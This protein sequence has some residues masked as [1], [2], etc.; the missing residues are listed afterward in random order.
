MDYLPPNQFNVDLCM[1]SISVLNRIPKHNQT[2]APYE[3]MMGKRMDQ[4]RYL[5]VEWGEPVVVKRPKGTSSD[6]GTTGQWAVVVRRVMNGT[7]VVKV[8]LIQTKKY[9][10][11][12][13]LVH[14]IAPD[15][16]LEALKSISVDQN[17]GLEEEG[18]MEEKQV[19]E[20]IEEVESHDN[21]DADADIDA[22]ENEEDVALIGGHDKEAVV[23]QSIKSIEGTWNDSNVKVEQEEEVVIPETMMLQP[24]I[25]THGPIPYVTRSGRISRPPNRLIETAYAI[26]NETYNHNFQDIE[27]DEAKQTI[28]CTYAMK[29][30]LFQTVLKMKPKEAMKA[31]REEVMKTIKLDIWEPVHP[32]NLTTEECNIIIPQMMNYLEKYNPD[33]T[34]DKYKVRVLTRG[35]KQIYS[36]E[37]EG[38]VARVESLLML[39]GIAIHKDLNIFK[40]DAVS[41]FMRTPMADDVKH[42]WVQLD[43]EWYKC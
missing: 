3:L 10:Y 34:F 31:L 37:S 16:V 32:K 39:L 41:A 22:I 15:W 24:A 36:G 33:M 29:A 5:C 6:L 2:E 20:L 8:Y 9:A 23:L 35:D 11:R 18:V 28:E 26:V 17:I 19:Q 40:V 27:N 21:K 42:K 14:A 43:R 1:D 38:P 25:Q 30:L 7:G 4:L 13:K 12:L